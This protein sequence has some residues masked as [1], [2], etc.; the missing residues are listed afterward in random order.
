MRPLDSGSPSPV[1]AG[2]RSVLDE[3]EDWSARGK[4]ALPLSSATSIHIQIP[5]MEH[6]LTIETFCDRQYIKLFLAE[7]RDLQS[8]YPNVPTIVSG[9]HFFSHDL[10]RIL[11]VQVKS[12]R[13]ADWLAYFDK[14]MTAGGEDYGQFDLTELR[15]HAEGFWNMLN[16]C[17]KDSAEMMVMAIKGVW[18]LLETDDLVGQALVRQLQTPGYGPM[19]AEVFDVFFNAMPVRVQ[20]LWL[21]DF[22][23]RSSAKKYKSPP[24]FIRWIERTG[25]QAWNSPTSFQVWFP[26]SKRDVLSSPD[27]FPDHASEDNDDVNH[28]EREGADSDQLDDADSGIFSDDASEGEEHYYD[29]Y[30]DATDDLRGEE[31][32]EEVRASRV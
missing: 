32:T 17:S 16:P 18:S 22:S 3:L 1:I 14:L 29:A 23:K 6:P 2:E 4:N 12:S 30:S 28:L 8:K 10:G 21:E 26:D 25:K 15:V 20:Q 24:R 27:V 7:T 19:L 31:Y 13:P 9:R 11:V 5:A